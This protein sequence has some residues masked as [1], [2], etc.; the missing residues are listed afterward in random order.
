MVLNEKFEIPT[1]FEMSQ[2]GKIRSEWKSKSP[3]QKWSH[4][5]GIGK[6]SLSVLGFPIFTEGSS[7][8]WYSYVFFVYTGIDAIL[9]LYTAYYFL[10]KGDSFS[11]FL[12]CTALLIGPLFCVCAKFL[13]I[14]IKR[15][16]LTTDII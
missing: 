15:N 13:L 3:L 14:N 16:S 1:L 4:L 6:V 2:I 11:D 9:V 12:P 7:V 10:F 8:Y 5:Y